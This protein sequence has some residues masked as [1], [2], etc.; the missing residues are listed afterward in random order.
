MLSYKK[1]SSFDY[2]KNFIKSKKMF[3]L[4]LVS[5]MV[6]PFD[7]FNGGQ[8]LYEKYHDVYLDKLRNVFSKHPN[9]QNNEIYTDKETKIGYLN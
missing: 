7:P 8:F 5:L 9:G 2:V 1:R 4:S 3:L 6:L